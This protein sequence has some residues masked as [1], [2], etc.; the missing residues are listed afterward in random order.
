[1]NLLHEKKEELMPNKAVIALFILHES[2]RKSA[3]YPE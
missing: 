2:Y 1:M 3:I